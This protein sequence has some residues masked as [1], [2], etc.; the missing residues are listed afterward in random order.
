MGS[1]ES[2]P[3][4]NKTKICCCGESKLDS[5]FDSKEAIRQSTKEN[6]VEGENKYK[7]VMVVPLPEHTS[8]LIGKNGIPISKADDK[9]LTEPITVSMLGTPSLIQEEKKEIYTSQIN[10]KA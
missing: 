10:K 5:G 8:V 1:D 9:P 6:E 7:S 4:E 2:K 3:E